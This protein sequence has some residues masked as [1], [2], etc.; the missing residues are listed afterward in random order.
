MKTQ[1]MDEAT[2][3]AYAGRAMDPQVFPAADGGWT[4][5][6]GSYTLTARR[7]RQMLLLL[8]V[9][10]GLLLAPGRAQAQA[11]CIE[12][13]DHHNPITSPYFSRLQSSGKVWVQASTGSV[14]VAVRIRECGKY[15][16]G[17]WRNGT[18]TTHFLTSWGYVTAQ[19]TGFVRSAWSKVLMR[20]LW[21]ILVPCPGTWL[22][23]PDAWTRPCPGRTS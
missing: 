15:L 5:Y 1:L 12:D 11:G 8:L 19:V 22:G 13:F 23:H 7:L 6:A 2:K 18:F 14:I 3:A 4:L 9:L 16:I 10:V 20:S 17:I 21:I